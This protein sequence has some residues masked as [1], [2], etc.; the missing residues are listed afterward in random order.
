MQYQC[1]IDVAPLIDMQVLISYPCQKPAK[2]P[3]QK[4]PKNPAKTL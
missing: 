3:I 1:F 4:L 2:N